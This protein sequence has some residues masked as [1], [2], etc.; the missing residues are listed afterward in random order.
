MET[1]KISWLSCDA[2]DAGDQQT[3]HVLVSTEKGCGFWLFAG[4]EAECPN[5]HAKGV[6]DADGE[7]AWVDWHEE[8]V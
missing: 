4:D 3:S 2:C 8:A 1:L 5:C 6:I 7:S